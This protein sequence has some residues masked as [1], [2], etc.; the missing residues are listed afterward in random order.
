MQV[1]QVI[2]TLEKALAFVR[3]VSPMAAAA[4][5]TAAGIGA[6]VGQV[7]DFAGGVL[8]EAQAA[9]EVIASRDLVTIEN[10]TALIRAENDAL[11]AQIAAG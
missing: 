9:G 4:G 11:A 7:S 8:A 3:A 5:P 1:S 6:I 10:L 2:A